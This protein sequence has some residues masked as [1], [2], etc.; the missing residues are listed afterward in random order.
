MAKKRKEEENRETLIWM[1]T[2][3]DLI[4]LMFT[5]FVLL[6][7]L[8]SLEAGKISQMQSAC[9][10]AIGVLFEGKSSE[11]GFRVIMSTKKEIDESALKAKELFRQFSGL[12]TRLLDVN[13][14]GSMEFEEQEKGMS[15]I[16]RDDLLFSSGR[17]EINPSGMSVL[18]TIGSRFEKFEGEVIVEGHTDN[19]PITTE[20]FPSN[21]ELSTGRAV[22]TV[23]YL[24]EELG[25]SP[26]VLSAAGYGD[27]KPRAPNDTPDN[28][29]KNRRIEIILKP[30]IL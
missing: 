21:W 25:V 23:K 7:S 2:F 8:C 20:R 14:R 13:K 17:A 22:S 26:V 24:T 10:D 5:F 30:Q 15:I 28:R 19:V 9:A 11:V 16:I 4:T 18:R 12:K 1:V 6:L 3:S 27:T 29:S